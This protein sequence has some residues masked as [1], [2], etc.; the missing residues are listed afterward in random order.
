MSR[1]AGHACCRR[2]GGAAHGGAAA[3][4]TVEVVI[5]NAADGELPDGRRRVEVRGQMAVDVYAA[6]EYAVTVA[7]VWPDT[8][9]YF[10]GAAF[11]PGSHAAA[12]PDA[13][14]GPDRAV[15]IAAGEAVTDDVVVP[16]DRVDWVTIDSP[17]DGVLMVDVAPLGEQ[18][19]VL[20]LDVYRSADL[21]VPVAVGRF[22][23]DQ[24][25]RPLTALG[26]RGRRRNAGGTV[27]RRSAGR[28]PAGDRCTPD[29]DGGC[30]GPRAGADGRRRRGR[31]RPTIG[32]SS[33]LTPGG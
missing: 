14:G 18:T 15:A 33:C 32:T 10:V 28:L 25:V 27:A 22:A 21:F 19:A 16:D 2:R 6:G 30:R 3:Q 11:L 8:V 20:A 24:G 4:G 31:G 7:P 26:R 9:A 23:W 1:C 5:S 13:D 12:A 17:T 29:V